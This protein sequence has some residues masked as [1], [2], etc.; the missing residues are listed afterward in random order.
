MTIRLDHTIIA[1]RDREAS[2]RFLTE[3]LGLPPPRHLGPFVVVDVGETQLDFAAAEGEVEPRHFAFRVDEADF[4][5]ILARLLERGLP[6]W[7]DP[8]HRRPGRINRW[9]D[10][11][12]LY[13]DDPDGHR[14]EILTRP[15]GSA[16][17]L[18]SHPHPLLGPE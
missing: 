18:A 2:A 3:L 11:R 10:G 6:Y 17:P 9:D 12:G 7:A 14:L 5:A 15:Y 4:D 1:A 8:F 13:F 16:G